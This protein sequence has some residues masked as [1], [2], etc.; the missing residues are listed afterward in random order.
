M[1]SKSQATLLYY[2]SYP[3]AWI[4]FPG[5]I[6]RMLGR[7]FICKV[8]KVEVVEAKIFQFKRPFGYVTYLPPASIW[9]SLAII[10][11]PF[12]VN[13]LTGLLI[14]FVAVWADG[15]SDL[16]MLA[17]LFLLWL[18]VAIAKHAFAQHEEGAMLRTALKAPG[19]PGL[20]KVIG[21]PIMVLI[22]AGWI[23]SVMLGD[24]VYGAFV[25]FAIPF[26]TMFALF[27]PF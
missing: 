26:G 11:G 20:A 9:R 8:L 13:T 17:Q 18:G 27:G 7:L 4:T 3:I 12:F 22:Y 1:S 21:Y 14:G 25:A 16:R 6:V 2:L 15:D 10:G 19:T 24:V 23:A 5:I